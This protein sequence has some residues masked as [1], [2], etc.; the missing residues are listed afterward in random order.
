MFNLV[1]LHKAGLDVGAEVPKDLRVSGAL[2]RQLE[3]SLVSSGMKCLFVAAGFGFGL[4][5]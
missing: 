4:Q 3:T 1:L 5:R 2:I